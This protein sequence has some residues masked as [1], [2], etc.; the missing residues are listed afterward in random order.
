MMIFLYIAA[1]VLTAF[2]IWSYIYFIRKDNEHFDRIINNIN[3][4]VGSKHQSSFCDEVRDA[5]DTLEPPS[6]TL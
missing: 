5:V 2:V 3:C 1:G 4:P 6:E